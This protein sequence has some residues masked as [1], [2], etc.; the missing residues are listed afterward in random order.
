MKKVIIF[1]DLPIATKI[2]MFLEKMTDVE[3][4]V[5][6]GN[7]MPHN[8]DP[9]EDVP[10]LIEYC[11]EKNIECY[12]LT[13][14]SQQFEKN[15]LTLGLSC[16][17]SKIIK[18]DVI[19]RFQHGVINMHGG[20]LPEFAGLCSVNHTILSGSNV[21]GGTLHYIDEG[22]DTGEIIRRCEIP[23]LPEDTAYD[24]FQKTQ[25]V[26]E[27]NMEAILPR[28]LEGKLPI[29]SRDELAGN[30]HVSHYYDKKDLELFRQI[31]LNALDHDEIDRRIR[32]FDFPGYEPAYIVNKNGRKVYLRYNY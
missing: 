5:V 15:E 19:E 18:P 2:V 29:V 11:K 3:V 12:T 13:E 16:R 17:F 26:L 9:W 23:V 8:D 30:G 28:A 31:D 14:I 21:G 1:G 7:E 27:E 32:G 4:G 24:L 10:L 22:I 25:I 6:I 20:L